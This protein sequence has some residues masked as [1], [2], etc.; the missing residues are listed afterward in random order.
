MVAQ[1]LKNTTVSRIPAAAFM[2]H[3]LELS[4]QRFE[5]D[6]TLLNL[7]KLAACDGIRILAGCVRVVREF[8]EFPNS[9]Q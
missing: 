5:S 4:T 8:Q 7:L 3:A 1:H 2:D 6:H 9:V